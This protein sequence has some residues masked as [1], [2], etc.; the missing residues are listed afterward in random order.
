VTQRK[1]DK[2]SGSSGSSG[3]GSRPRTR[4]PRNET[5][6]SSG[7]FFFEEK[8]AVTASAPS[9]AAVEGQEETEAERAQRL[10]EEDDWMSQ[11]SKDDPDAHTEI[12]S[13][14]EERE[15]KAKATQDR[16]DFTCLTVEEVARSY[17]VREIRC[18]LFF[19]LCLLSF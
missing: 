8:E 13:E 19:V 4:K 17:Q 3:T 11:F 7:S 18:F 1:G 5:A 6:S 12:Y 15:R 2:G 14:P 9:A 16:Y 10:Q